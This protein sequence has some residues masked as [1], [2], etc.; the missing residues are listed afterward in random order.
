MAKQKILFEAGPMLDSHKTGV[1]YYLSHLVNSLQTHYDDELEL[2]GY[3]F[4]FLN[5]RGN[6][7]PAKTSLKF[8][9]IS[10]F[11]GK[12][13][14]VCR[15]LG[16]QPF[17]ESFIRKKFDTVFFANYVALPQLKRRKTVLVVYDLSYLDAPEYTQQANLRYLRRFCSPS[18]RSADVIITISEF[19]RQRLQHHFPS[20]KAKIVVTPIPPISQSVDKIPLSDKLTSLGLQ[21]GNFILCVGTIEP[22]KNLGTLIEAYSLLSPEIQQKYSLVLAGGKGW[23]DEAILA[24]VDTQKA[25]GLNI[26]LTGYVSEEEKNALYSNTACFVLPSHYEGFGMPILEAMQHGAPCALSDIPVFNEVAGNAA[27]YFNKDAS[28]DIAAKLETI[29][30]AS[31]LRDDLAQKGTGR[32]KAF[33]WQKN[34]ALVYQALK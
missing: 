16:F 22:R 26:I 19:T 30:Q 32:L 15:R 12:I 6:K 10:L 18:I 25:K 33:S 4:N 2:T 9:K 5:R 7:E 14:S 29:L 24:S 3:Y 20:L 23:K 11:P 34:A 13:I 31:T 17:L 1:G 28:K 21:K 8:H 27:V